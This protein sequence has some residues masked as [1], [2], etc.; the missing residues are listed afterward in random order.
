MRDTGWAALSWGHKAKA[1]LGSHMDF[2]VAL[3]AIQSERGAWDCA[4][5]HRPRG[6]LRGI[7]R[8]LITTHLDESASKKE[9]QSR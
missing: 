3:G 4:K 6:V 2:E 8:M 1:L 9:H 5:R 7:S